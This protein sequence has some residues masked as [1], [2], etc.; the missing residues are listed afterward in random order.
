M[1]QQSGYALSE[2]VL[3]CISKCF[4]AQT[5]AVSMIRL[6]L[7]VAG[8]GRSLCD[9]EPALGGFCKS[10]TFFVR[11]TQDCSGSKKTGAIGFCGTGP[12]ASVF[13]TIVK[14][15]EKNSSGFQSV[16]PDTLSGA[17][18]A[19]LNMAILPR[20]LRPAYPFTRRANK[21]LKCLG[22]RHTWKVC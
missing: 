12:L 4:P 1:T 9:C 14:W 3:L 5:G 6:F 10:S 11:T 2:K 13:S 7:P 17:P 22:F 20:E 8:T 21:R 19:I 18:L 16:V 15:S